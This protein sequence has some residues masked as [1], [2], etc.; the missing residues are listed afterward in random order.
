[1]ECIFCKL[2]KGEIPAE[3][4][5]ENEKVLVFKDINPQAKVHLL[6]IPRQH[7]LNVNGLEPENAQIMGEMFLAAKKAAELAGIAESGYR[8]LIN[9]GPDAGQEVDHIHIHI[10]GGEKLT[11]LN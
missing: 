5:F 6:V 11:L 4:V 2:E 9:S 1:M 3:I 10:L 7:I 8:T